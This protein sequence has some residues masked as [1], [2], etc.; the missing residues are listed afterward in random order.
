MPTS[1][2]AR[3]FQAFQP[4][5]FMH[6]HAWAGLGFVSPASLGTE[7]VNRELVELFDAYG[8]EGRRVDSVNE[9]VDALG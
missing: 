8:F 6:P 7:P 5:S 9:L 2:A 1:R 4:R 3:S